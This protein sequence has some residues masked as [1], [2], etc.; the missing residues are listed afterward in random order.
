MK[1]EISDL[2]AKVPMYTF[3]V[4][5][6]NGNPDIPIGLLNS[7]QQKLANATGHDKEWLQWLD[8][9]KNSLEFLINSGTNG[10]I[11]TRE[12]IQELLAR[13]FEN[14]S[15]KNSGQMKDFLKEAVLDRKKRVHQLPDYAL[16]SA[17]ATVNWKITTA[18]FRRTAPLLSLAERYLGLTSTRVNRPTVA[19]MPGRNPGECWPMNGK[20]I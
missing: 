6:E 2:I 10:Q 20:F 18:S 3:S 15:R 7:L 19:L 12:Q 9:N 17:G 4:V 13:E 16:G 5:G 8:K 14:Y 11:V 1:K